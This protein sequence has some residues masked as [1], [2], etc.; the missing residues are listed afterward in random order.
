MPGQTVAVPAGDDDD[1]EKTFDSVKFYEDYEK[2]TRG[3]KRK[4]QPDVYR[5]GQYGEH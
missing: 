5:P 3:R 4:Q 1:D 2:R